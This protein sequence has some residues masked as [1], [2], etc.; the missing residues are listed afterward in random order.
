VGLPLA[1][2]WGWLVFGEWPSVAMWIGCA[3]IIGAGLVV[4]LREQATQSPQ[5]GRRARWGRR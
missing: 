4:F 5:P 3:M 1:I 2:F